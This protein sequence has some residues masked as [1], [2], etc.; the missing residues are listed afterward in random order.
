MRNCNVLSAHLVDLPDRIP[1]L[2]FK[3]LV[4]LHMSLILLLSCYDLL[5]HGW[6]FC[7]LILFFIFYVTYLVYTTTSYATQLQ[8]LRGI[9]MGLHGRM[10]YQNM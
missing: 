6:E 10:M 5:A 4:L 3:P 1:L 2:P 7:D 9:S 8:Q